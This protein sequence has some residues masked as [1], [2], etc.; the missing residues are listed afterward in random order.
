IF[1]AKDFRY[2]NVDI[3]GENEEKSSTKF[4]INSMV[5]GV[6]YRMKKIR[7]NEDGFSPTSAVYRPNID[8]GLNVRAGVDIST[9]NSDTFNGR[10][11]LEMAFNA[12][13]G[14]NRIGFTGEG[15]FMGDNTPG[16]LGSSDFDALN[17]TFKKVS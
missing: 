3:W 4:M 1:G 10:A 6:S 11:Y 17:D 8:Y 12:H 2:W 5:G 15:A 9:Q 16:G 13:G 7:A 14:L